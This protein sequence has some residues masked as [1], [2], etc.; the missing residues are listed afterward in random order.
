MNRLRLLTPSVWLIHAFVWTLLIVKD[1]ATSFHRLDYPVD[2]SAVGTYWLLSAGYNLVSAAAFY[3]SL[4]G[5]A[6]PLLRGT[7]DRQAVGRA[8]GGL[9]LTL[10]GITALRYGLEMGIF[11]PLFGYDNY[12]RNPDL[13][14]VWFVKN[15][16]LYYFVYVLYGL[17]YAFIANRIVSERHQ[18]ETE[19]A[20]QAAELAFLHSQLNPHFLFNTINDI[21]A[22]VYRQSKEAPDALL[23]LSDLLRY[24]LHDARHERVPLVKEIDY[25]GSLIELQRLGLKDALCLDYRLRG[26]LD[27]QLIAPLL[28]VSFV[29]NAFKH[30]LV[31]DSRHPVQLHLTVTNT[32][33]DFTLHNTKHSQQKDQMGGIGLA[34]VRRRLALLYPDR[35][36]LTVTNESETYHVNLHLEL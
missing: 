28:L 4:V 3:G 29:E 30:G 8:L 21:Y 20:R 7:L 26:S 22:L 27:G 12:S 11:K 2:K 6:R 32:T 33:L 25:L 9:L 1:V 24:M 23:K 36:E 17:V 5:V 19:Q 15:C 34:N 14:L 10:I 35:H 31:S 13:T 16:V 18:R